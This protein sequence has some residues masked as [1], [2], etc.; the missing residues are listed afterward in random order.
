VCFRYLDEGRS[1]LYARMICT[2]LAQHY[3]NEEKYREALALK[4]Y[5]DGWAKA[6]DKD[7][8][9]QE[10]DLRYM[11]SFIHFQ[12]GEYDQA[13]VSF[14]EVIRTGPNSQAAMDSDYWKAMCRLLQQQYDEAYD[15]FMAYRQKY[16]RASFA[17]AAL[18]RAGV[19]R[20]GVKKFGEAKALFKEF[21]DSYPQDSLLPEALTMY[22]D[23]LG[24][25]GM[26][27]EALANYDRALRI[28]EKNYNNTTNPLLKKRMV[29]PATYAVLQAAN[30]LQA[31]A[32]VHAEQNE[33]PMAEIKYR[34]IIEWMERYNKIFGENAD[35][36]QGVFW[37][38]KAQMEL[39][40]VDQAV[41]AYLNA[42]VHYGADPAQKGVASILFDLAGMIKKRLPKDRFEPTL[43]VIEQERASAKSAT[44]QIRLDVLLAEL[45][46]TADE[47]GRS[48]LARETKLDDIPPY[49]LAL[50]CSELL[51]KKDYSRAKEF[52]DHFAAQH[53][54][55]PFR[56]T[57]YQL[58]AEELYG[59]TQTDEAYELATGALGM[60]GATSDTGWAQL[61]KGNVELIRGEYK[62]AVKTFN[63]IFN[64]RA[65]RGPITAEAMF[66]M[67][68]AWEQQ[69]N[70]EKAFAFFQ[71][72]YL[73]YKA[74]DGGRWAAEGY[75]RSAQCL[76]KMGRESAARNTYRAMLL[77]EYV[78]DLP[79]AQAA[80]DVLGPAEVLELLAGSTNTMETVGAEVAP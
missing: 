49:G 70:Y 16:S 52:Y 28:V 10:T 78:R 79:Q 39:G 44:L 8:R 62:T 61:M 25:D 80:K 55:S 58:R 18:F 4:K 5:A 40:E 38:G 73:L 50:M 17:S 41:N 3:L 30:A 51:E 43:L 46:G 21:I 42:V 19:C 65:W 76:K 34:R 57:A 74:Y 37:I 59:Q 7:E 11:F 31:D 27:D 35:W 60:Y 23:L 68:D 47:L 66:R 2:R 56:V 14:D 63:M 72:T 64:V 1:G 32:E 53:E 71:R 22:G 6:S 26:I 15:Q 54:N 77:D 29:A 24:A 12:L 20:F 69:K 13:L 67:A 45:N 9:I 75:L 33:A 36:A 48:L